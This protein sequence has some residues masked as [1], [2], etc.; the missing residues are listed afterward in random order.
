MRRDQAY[1]YLAL[2]LSFTFFLCIIYYIHIE[3]EVGVFGIGMGVGVGA[4]RRGVVW[5]V[6]ARFE[7]PASGQTC[8]LH[9]RF[10][11]L[12][13]PFVVGFSRDARREELE[14]GFIAPLLGNGAACS[15]LCIYVCIY[16]WMVGGQM[17]RYVVD[18]W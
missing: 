12:F 13:L 15:E 11:S 2:P 6:R 5:C 17:V 9:F 7:I 10:A 1:V 3:I 18:V 14:F 16:G 8:L 4:A